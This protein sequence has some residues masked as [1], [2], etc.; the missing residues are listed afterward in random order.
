MKKRIKYFVFKVFLPLQIIVGML[1]FEGPLTGDAAGN[2]QEETEID[3]FEFLT[4]SMTLP[5]EGIGS[6]RPVRFIISPAEASEKIIWQS[7]DPD[8]AA[9]CSD[10]KVIARSPGKAIIMGSIA[11]GPM[12]QCA[13]TVK[14][15]MSRGVLPDDLE[16]IREEAFLN[17]RAE[18]IFLSDR[19]CS[20]GA[21]AFAGGT[22]LRYIAVPE[23]VKHIGENAFSGHSGVCIVSPAGSFAQG[24]ALENGF[25]WMED[26][27][28]M[29]HLALDTYSMI[30]QKGDTAQIRT[31]AAG[32]EDDSVI[33]KSANTS[34][35][36]VEDGRITAGRAGTTTVRAVLGTDPSV[37]A[38]CTV[39]VVDTSDN[40]SL[41]VSP[42][43]CRIKTGES[44]R[45][46]AAIYPEAGAV[47]TWE[48][49]RPEVAEVVNGLVTGLIPGKTVITV[50]AE[51]L[52]LEA[53]CTVV[54]EAVPVSSVTLDKT[55]FTMEE[56]GS[57]VITG[58]VLPS[59]ATDKSLVWTSSDAS[60]V[61]VAGGELTAYRAGTAVITAE[62]ADGSGKYADCLVTVLEKEIPE[63]PDPQ[64]DTCSCSETYSGYYR[65][66]GT[67]GLLAISSGHGPSTSYTE[68]GTIPE[69]TKIYIS[70][71]SG[72]SGVSGNWGHVT[73][74]GIS[75][76]CAMRYLTPYIDY[77]G[78][79]NQE[80]LAALID[81]ANE[82]ADYTWI[83]NVDIPVYNNEWTDNQTEYWYKAGTLM[84]SI[85]YTLASSKKTLETYAALSDAN[86]HASR[87]F[88]YSGVTM[89]GPSYGCD[90]SGLVNDVLWTADPTIGHD[91]QTY[92][93]S[94]KAWMYDKVDWTD[95][96]PGDVLGKT[97]HVIIVIAVSGE[98]MTIVESRGN[99]SSVGAIRC[100]NMTERPGGGYYVCGTCSYCNGADKCGPI[101][102][103][104][105]KTVMKNQ[106][107]TIY[108]YKYLYTD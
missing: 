88:T 17:T 7:S 72:P 85:P 9:V 3:N 56:G 19:C 34:V 79:L 8:V 20:I 73:Y 51:S 33:W 99:G 107:Y 86:K 25:D 14:E 31:A 89:W 26:E 83:P 60:V 106:G 81:R 15:N 27:T 101:R 1:F 75:G 37:S 16:V 32:S 100:R 68:L 11:G 47:L 92:L 84:H 80:K 76:F 35:A 13:V 41:S 98:N 69:G 2:G 87:N 104:T 55:S 30:L 66:A 82:W 95:L 28:G 12:E 102:R 5:D 105:T 48:S 71:A 44:I 108:R 22:M 57:A 39:T 63:D 18:R 77:S 70:K 58:T 64:Q 4:Y 53:A 74:N 49:D 97:G 45:L 96:A 43:G 94:S 46:N 91:G 65:V 62:A 10:G 40:C 61:S 78:T 50:R 6:I 54:V 93:A 29:P 42:S 59:N 24:Y 103:L 36:R 90:C 52:G 38:A 23:S 21:K 67:D